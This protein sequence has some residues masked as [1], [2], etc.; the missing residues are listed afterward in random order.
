MSSDPARR[1][2]LFRVVYLVLTINFL[3]PAAIYAL[4]PASAIE[5]MTAL[6]VALGTP[7][8]PSPEQSLF[9]HVLGVGNVA[10]LGFC[11]LL[12]L[13]DLDRWYPVLVPLVFLKGCSVVGFLAAYRTSGHASF[14][15]ATLFDGATCVALVYFARGARSRPA[16]G[17]P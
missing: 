5:G 13:L 16:A 6:G 15:A 12:L 17:A 4:S 11:C 3:I 7:D 9:W 1:R 10:T 2:K 8:Y 14:L